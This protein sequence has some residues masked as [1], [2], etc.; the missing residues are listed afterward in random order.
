MR[1][2]PQ[3][4]SW[5]DFEWGLPVRRQQRQLND[6]RN[7]GLDKRSRQTAAH[8]DEQEQWERRMMGGRWPAE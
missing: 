2:Q 4:E 1:K 5:D 8:R 3:Y 7:P 6:R